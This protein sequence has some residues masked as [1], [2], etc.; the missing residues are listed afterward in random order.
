M[1][2]RGIDRHQEVTAH[3]DLHQLVLQGRALHDRAV[4]EALQGLVHKIR[5]FLTATPLAGDAT[6]AGQ[7]EVSMR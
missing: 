4:F 7:E 5:C 6:Y 3:M 1:N 2:A